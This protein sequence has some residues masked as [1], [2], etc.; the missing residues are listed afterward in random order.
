[1]FLTNEAWFQFVCVQWILGRGGKSLNDIDIR[2]SVIASMKQFIE[3][4]KYCLVMD[5]A[6]EEENVW[7]VISKHMFD[8]ASE[9]PFDWNIILPS[10]LD[11]DKK[12]L[13]RTTMTY[14]FKSLY[15]AQRTNT[16]DI[17]LD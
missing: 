8:A 1:M 15:D 10:G 16:D 5:S 6:G 9:V 3:L 17:P 14:I 13:Y 2:H 12:E 4:A 11:E 7:Q